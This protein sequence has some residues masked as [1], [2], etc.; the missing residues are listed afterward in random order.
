MNHSWVQW[1]LED[2]IGYLW[3]WI[4]FVVEQLLLSVVGY[5]VALSLYL[6]SNVC[7]TY[8]TAVRYVSAKIMRASD[9]LRGNI[10]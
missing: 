5:I 8:V 7:N 2:C 4:W 6:V 9:L 3:K 10:P 1:F